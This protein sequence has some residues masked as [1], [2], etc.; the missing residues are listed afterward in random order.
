MNNIIDINT[1]KDDNLLSENLK[2]IVTVKSFDLE[3]I[4]KRY[5]LSKK[6]SKNITGSV[7]RREKAKGG[8]V[9]IEIDK[10]EIIHYEI[11]LETLEPRGIDCIQDKL[12][13]SSE[14]KVFVID[15]NDNYKIEND[16]FS[17]I[18]TVKFSPFD[19]NNILISSSGLDCFFEYNYPNN[20]ELFNWFAW[21]NGFDEG[22]SKELE[23]Y[24][25]LTK[26]TVKAKFYK[27]N[28]I[29]YKLIE[30]PLVDTLPTAQRAAFINSVYYNPIEKNKWIA[31]LFH[32][33]K[34][35]E[36]SSEKQEVL[37]ENLTSPHGGKIINESTK[38]VTNT[39]QGKVELQENDKQF[40]FDF[41]NL[42][43][44]VMHPNQWLQNSVMHNNKVL[45]ID[46][47]RNSFVY[48][49]YKNKLKSIIPFESN[50]A[51]QDLT[52]IN[53]KLDIEK[54]KREITK[55]KL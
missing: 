6:S 8:I 3:A 52:V 46:S 42:E 49:D 36:I 29:D 41:Q 50:W 11:L 23:K 32:K 44:N 51:I 48:F 40:V 43:N 2:L 28:N 22:Y 16:W 39:A 37:F 9:Y 19:S 47:N 34:V 33:G 55:L 1:F 21:E 24:I 13:F 45:T 15:N 35:I 5:L 38:M 4:R 54:V 31:T 26:D 10:G 7:E 12:T 25:K 20:K 17:Y 27:K 30:N 14:N 53:D 18:H